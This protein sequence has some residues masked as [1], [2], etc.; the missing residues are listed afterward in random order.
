[1]SSADKGHNFIV[2]VVWMKGN[3][4]V[5][6]IIGAVVIADIDRVL[7]DKIIFVS[8]RNKLPGCNFF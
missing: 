5:T 1:M 7:V 8:R 3:E 6:G 2:V 4:V